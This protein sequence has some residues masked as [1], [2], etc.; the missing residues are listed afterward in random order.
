MAK[1]V[2][3]SVVFV[4]S[5][6]CGAARTAGRAATSGIRVETRMLIELERIVVV[7]DNVYAVVWGDKL[8]QQ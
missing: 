6:C 2:G 3:N 4:N 1:C 8:G 5:G 7:I